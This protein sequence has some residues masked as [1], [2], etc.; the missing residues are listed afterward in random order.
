MLDFSKLNP[1]LVR[2]SKPFFNKKSDQISAAAEAWHKLM[3][4]LDLQATLRKMATVGGLAGWAGNFK[5]NK[6]SVFSLSDYVVVAADGSQIYPDRHSGFT[7]YLINTGVAVLRYSENSSAYFTSA[8]H[9][10]ADTQNLSGNLADAVDCLRH[11]LE[12]SAGLTQVKY[13]QTISKK[14]LIYLADGSLIPWHLNDL[15]DDMAQKLAQNYLAQQSNFWNLNVPFIGYVS[16]PNSKDLINLI[17]AC[18]A[19]L[20]HLSV[21]ITCLN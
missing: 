16:L 3:L 18:F 20:R 2:V 8:P 15:S 14:N 7:A 5:K 9:F 12:L 4:D 21:V 19:N 1:Q 13:E 10:F 17:R 11:E 6:H